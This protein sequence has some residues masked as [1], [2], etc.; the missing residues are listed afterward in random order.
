MKLFHF[1]CEKRLLNWLQV[2]KN[3]CGQIRPV[4]IGSQIKTPVCVI[5]ST[6]ILFVAIRSLF[7]T[8][9]IATIRGSNLSAELSK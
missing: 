5:R 3:T 6:I 8:P 1:V 2:A 7:L 4:A 9:R